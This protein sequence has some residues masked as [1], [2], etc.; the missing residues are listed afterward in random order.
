MDISR[1]PEICKS[2]NIYLEKSLFNRISMPSCVGL[3][4]SAR[5]VMR[6]WKI[7]SECPPEALHGR[8]ERFLIPEDPRNIAAENPPVIFRFGDAFS[9]EELSSTDAETVPVA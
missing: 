6:F 2:G 4:P 1:I 7:G 9:G 8:Q 3:N 5:K